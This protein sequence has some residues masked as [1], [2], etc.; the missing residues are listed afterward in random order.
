MKSDRQN[1]GSMFRRLAPVVL[2]LLSSCGGEVE[3]SNAAGNV[4]QDPDPVQVQG[5]PSADPALEE[6]V[7]SDV[8]QAAISTSADAILSGINLRRV[9]EGLLPWQVD[10]P[11]VEA[12]YERSVDMAIR[13]YYDHTAPGEGE[14]EVLASLQ[15][16]SYFGQ[17]AELVF[18]TQEPLQEVS[19][20]TLQAWFNDA[21]H[22]AVLM[23]P[24]FRYV[25]LGLMGDGSQ[26]IVTMILVEGRP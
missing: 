5:S 2:L 10:S 3:F 24:A 4:P 14:V 18:V 16:G 19:R 17:A 23:S 12:A 22:E 9:Q 25:G 26:W 20:A 8:L 11:L 6:N 1:Y 21:N 15:A 7:G 13:G